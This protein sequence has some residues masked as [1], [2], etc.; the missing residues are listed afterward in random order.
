MYLPII[1]FVG[2]NFSQNTL[3]DAK[4]IFQVIPQRNAAK[5]FATLNF[6]V[7]SQTYAQFVR[8]SLLGEAGSFPGY[9]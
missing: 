8:H 9:L 6:F 5:G 4:D 7:M 3:I 1:F 2:M